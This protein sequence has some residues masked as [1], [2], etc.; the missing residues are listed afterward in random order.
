MTI[1]AWIGYFLGAIMSVVLLQMSV[2][3]F[4]DAAPSA[5][6]LLPDAGFISRL[7]SDVAVL[8]IGHNWVTVASSESGLAKTLYGVGALV[9]LP[10]GLPRC[11]P[12]QPT[13]RWQGRGLLTAL[14]V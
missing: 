2:M 1:S 12:R 7:P 5:M 8:G 3:V 9:V 6:V 13:R 11:V 10:A 4:S 14:R